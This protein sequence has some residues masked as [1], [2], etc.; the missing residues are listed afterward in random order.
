[1][2]KI[3]RNHTVS[4]LNEDW[5]MII[6]SLS[7]KHI[8]RSGELVYIKKFEDYFIVLNVIHNIEENHGVFIVIKEYQKNNK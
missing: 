6:P 8:P 2:F 7:L 1:M 4:V 5:D 3:F